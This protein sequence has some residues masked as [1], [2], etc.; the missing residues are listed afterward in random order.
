MNLSV[1]VTDAA[2]GVP[3]ADLQV[4]LRRITVSGWIDLAEERTGPDG[5]FTALL[6]ALYG[7]T[8]FQLELDIAR[9]YSVLGSVPL[10]PRVIMLFRVGDTD[11]DLHL[12]LLISPNLL[13]AYRGQCQ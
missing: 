5:R 13:V 8:T 11:E 10:F 9:Y 2:H 12:P 4:G 6:G 1:H 7:S 3:A